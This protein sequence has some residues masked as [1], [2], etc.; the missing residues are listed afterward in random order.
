M[1]DKIW[2]FWWLCSFL[3]NTP[4]SVK[5]FPNMLFF[6]L[7]CHYCLCVFANPLLLFPL[8]IDFDSMESYYTIEDGYVPPLL[9]PN[10]ATQQQLK[11][12]FEA[13]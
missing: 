11:K 3:G 9:L 7:P 13:S 2:S 8:I 1:A 5:L 4:G 6:C 10:Y 12:T